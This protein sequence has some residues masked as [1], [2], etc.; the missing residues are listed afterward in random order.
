VEGR[1][2]ELGTL[3]PDDEIGTMNLVTPAKRIAAAALVRDGMSV[4]LSQD[5]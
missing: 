2:V 5:V 3:G 1:A 4:S